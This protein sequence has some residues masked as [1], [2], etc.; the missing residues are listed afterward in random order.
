MNIIED[1]DASFFLRSDDHV[2]NGAVD[3]LLDW[4]LLDTDVA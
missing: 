1:N 3:I 4:T 2:I